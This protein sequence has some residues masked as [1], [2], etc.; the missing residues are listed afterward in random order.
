MLVIDVSEKIA[1]RATKHCV[2]ISLSED[3]Y[4]MI[5]TNH[6]KM[7]DDFE[8][9]SSDYGFLKGT[10]RFVCCSGMYEFPAG[11]VIDK[12]G[13][14]NR[15]DMAKILDKIQNSKILTKRDKDS[16]IPGLDKWLSDNQ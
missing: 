13:K 3:K 8:I 2:C 5:N 1:Y 14:L 7:Y 12:V 10:N 16:V 9:K 4:L 11:K 15:D 6:R